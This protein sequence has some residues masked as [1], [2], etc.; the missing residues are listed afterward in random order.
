M[1]TLSAA[2][3]EAPAVRGKGCGL[4]NLKRGSHQTHLINKPPCVTGE[5][6]ML[7]QLGTCLLYE[8]LELA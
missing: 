2:E 1:L 8:G 7:R 3:G 6:A 5:I 4:R